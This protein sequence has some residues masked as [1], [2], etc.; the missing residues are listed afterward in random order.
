M[1]DLISPLILKWCWW[2]L[3]IGR[4]MINGN[5]EQCNNHDSSDLDFPVPSYPITQREIH[6]THDLQK[7]DINIFNTF[8][9]LVI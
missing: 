9:G 1:F 4:I 3:E 8:L 6:V 5:C 7:C 2:N